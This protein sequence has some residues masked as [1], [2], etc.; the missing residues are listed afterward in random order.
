MR[1]PLKHGFPVRWFD[2]AW[3]LLLFIYFAF[4]WEENSIEN[5]QS[6][7]L[8]GGSKYSISYT[9]LLCDIM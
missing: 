1:K 2:S 6:T 7:P 3:Q 8:A 4:L 9:V 5:L